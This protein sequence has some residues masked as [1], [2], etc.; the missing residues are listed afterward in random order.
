MR[1]MAYGTRLLASG[2]LP[3]RV[4]GIGN[5]TL[6]GTGKTPLVETVAR[7]LSSEGWRVVILSRGYG[8]RATAA[9]T[10][11]SDGERVQATA[12]EVGDEPVLLARRTPGVPVVVG[13]DRLRAGRWAMERFRPDVALLDDGFQQRR[14][15]KNVEVV[16]VDAR[17]PWGAGGLFPRGTLRE[18]RS[19]LARA[20][21]VV[22]T[23][24]DPAA[25]VA[26]DEVRRWAP[27][28]AIAVGTYEVESVVDLGSG[29]ALPPAAREV[30]VIGFAGLAAPQRFAATLARLGLVPREFV[31]FPDHH[32]YRAHEVGELE[33]RAMMIGAQALV[34]TEKDA[35]RLPPGRGLPVWVVRVRLRLQDDDGAWWRA[36]DAR[37]RTVAATGEDGQPPG[38]G[39]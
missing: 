11:V 23:G 18:P 6:G 5:L 4:V 37:L 29:A 19:A 3:C 32:A 2:W 36:L 15:R 13:R 17:A 30:P 39:A 31:A 22:L 8:G 25:P 26:L 34:T 28:A 24:T 10:L 33:R 27:R 16:C 1:R 7:R 21:L 14:L 38:P 20:D 35:V 9:V 12:E